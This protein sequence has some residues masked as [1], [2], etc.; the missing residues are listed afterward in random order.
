[1]IAAVA[2]AAVAAA[3]SPHL[4]M[5]A[6]RPPA[7]RGTGF[8]HRERVRLRFISAGEITRLRVR[9]SRHGRIHGTFTDVTYDRCN[10]FV[11]TAVGA[12]GDRASVLRHPLPECAP[13]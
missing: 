8:H 5:T 1:M 11:I 6:L 7:V 10:G 9:A 12:T 13:A 4:E 3:H 2:L